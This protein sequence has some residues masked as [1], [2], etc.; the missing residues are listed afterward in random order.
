MRFAFR[1]GDDA[2]ARR[3]ALPIRIAAE[4]EPR[5][6]IRQRVVFEIGEQNVTSA[7][8]GC[9]CALIDYTAINARR[10]SMT[11]ET[12]RLIESCDRGS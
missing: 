11:P 8:R 1:I 12:K 10:T 4:D 6:N 2:L 7:R 5:R 3:R 9:A